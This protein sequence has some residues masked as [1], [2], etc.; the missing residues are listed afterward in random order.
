MR[1][2]AALV[3]WVVC[4]V[5]A[6]GVLTGCTSLNRVAIEDAPAEGAPRG[7]RLA[8]HRNHKAIPA[9]LT[10][11]GA[12]KVITHLE[13]ENG[14]LIEHPL[15]ILPAVGAET[16]AGRKVQDYVKAASSRTFWGHIAFWS[17]P[18][19]VGLPVVIAGAGY[20]T[21]NA[22]YNSGGPNLLLIPIGTSLGI[23]VA[24]PFVSLVGYLFWSW[25][26]DDM[27]EAKTA[28]FASYNQ[29][30]E[31]NLGLDDTSHDDEPMSSSNDVSDDGDEDD[32]AFDEGMQVW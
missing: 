24:A 3:R 6:V 32:E 16:P 30:L 12:S 28:A 14:T 15:D 26:K 4:V 9:L 22:V 18:L 7:E 10:K 25:R 1:S 20:M 31:V 11:E 13:L 21:A 2:I 19:G 5:V 23:C 17:L 29:S 8:Y 27:R